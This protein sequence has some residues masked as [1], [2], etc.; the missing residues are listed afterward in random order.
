M[1]SFLKKVFSLKLTTQIMFFAVIFATAA[2][3]NKEKAA[4]IINGIHALNDIMMSVSGMVMK[5]A[6]FGICGNYF[7]S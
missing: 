3:K 6:P 5:F 1:M 2:L 4:S 7:S